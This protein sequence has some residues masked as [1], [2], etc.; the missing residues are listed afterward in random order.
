MVQDLRACK[1]C[2]AEEALKAACKLP[3]ATLQSQ[4]QWTSTGCHFSWAWCGRKACLG[5]IDVVLIWVVSPREYAAHGALL[6]DGVVGFEVDA[7][8]Q[9]R[10]KHT[11]RLAALPERGLTLEPVLAAH[12]SQVGSDAH[13]CWSCCSSCPPSACPEQVFECSPSFCVILVLPV[14]M[15]HQLKCKFYAGKDGR[16]SAA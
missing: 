15:Q 16:V 12:H 2:R 3:N 11:G 7:V 9:V 6:E 13:V 4:Q 5:S 1:L 10:G 8:A 14:R